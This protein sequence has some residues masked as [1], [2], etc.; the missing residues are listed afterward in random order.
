MGDEVK[1]GSLGGDAEEG[2]V[3]EEAHGDGGGLAGVDAAC[4]FDEL[5]DASAIGERV[6]DEDDAEHQEQC[7]EAGVGEVDEDGLDGWTVE[8]TLVDAKEPEGREPACGGEV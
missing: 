3:E 5:A 2:G 6:G 1:D 7:G 4:A 8:E